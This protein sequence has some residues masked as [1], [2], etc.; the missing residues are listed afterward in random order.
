MA[1]CRYC[2]RKL[3]D[4]EVCNCRDAAAPAGEW[5]GQPVSPT[6][7]QTVAQAS[8]VPEQT[9][10]QV[11]PA[12]EQTAGEGTQQTKTQ[13]HLF[14]PILKLVKSLPKDPLGAPV[15]FYHEAS[16]PA[17]VILLAM[18]A[19]TYT[20]TVFLNMGVHGIYSAATGWYQYYFTVGQVF[21]SLFFPT[22]YLF[23][24]LCALIGVSVLVAKGFAKGTWSIKNA[25]A[26][27]ASISVPLFGAYI[28]RFISLCFI[29]TT[30]TATGAFFTGF[31]SAVFVASSYACALV[32]LVQ[33]LH[34][35]KEKL[36]NRKSL[37]L[38]LV[39]AAGVVIVIDTLLWLYM[40][41]C[42]SFF[43]III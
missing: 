19:F 18:L 4:G 25:F 5:N 30:G 26:G 39:T 16:I 2:G 17:S 21:M 32:S 27:I 10:A 43:T 36:P 22:N 28:L 13:G 33:L 8:P 29:N 37:F 12:P 23:I 35:L 11:Y 14:A 34:L 40:G 31:F 15:E 42:H 1:F 7:E 9:V 41:N 38:T 20:I 24:M 3:E 6:P